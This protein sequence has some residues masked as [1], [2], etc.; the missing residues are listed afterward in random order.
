M[1]MI[2]FRRS[3]YKDIS[4]CAVASRATALLAAQSSLGGH[5]I[6]AQKIPWYYRGIPQYSEVYHSSTTVY[7]DVPW[8]YFTMVLLASTMVVPWYMTIY[9]GTTMVK[10]GNPQE[11][12]FYHSTLYWYRAISLVHIITVYNFTIYSV[13]N[14][15]VNLPF[16]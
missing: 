7:Y 12:L 13:T 8:Y 5:D 11:S 14:Y 6:F 15:N 2:I 3:L 9:C 16:Q 10:H 4:I 1:Y